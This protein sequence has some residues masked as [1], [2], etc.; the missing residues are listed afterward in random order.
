MALSAICVVDVILFVIT[1]SYLLFIVFAL[2]C[3]AIH[4]LIFRGFL[5][6]S[7]GMNN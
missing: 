5:S 2:H 4:F 3:F 7:Q 6:T 1:Y